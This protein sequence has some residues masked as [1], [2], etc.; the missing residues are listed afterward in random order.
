MT[1]VALISHRVHRTILS[2]WAVYAMS[3]F[4]LIGVYSL[5][6]VHLDPIS[7]ETWGMVLGSLGAYL[8]GAAVVLGVKPG[9][10]ARHP[11][12]SERWFA[13]VR[14][15]RFRVFYALT[16]A[17]GLIGA[18]GYFL[19]IQRL[20]GLQMLLSNPGFIR[21]QQSGSEFMNAFF[22]W[23]FPF[24]MNWLGIGLGFAWILAE[25][26]AAPVW[27]WLAV[28]VQVVVNLA[29]V[30]RSQMLLVGFI[31]LFLVALKR[32]RSGVVSELVALVS[33]VG[34]LALYFTFAGEMLGKTSEHFADL[35][36][37]FRGPEVL[38]PFAGFYIYVAANIP[39]LQAFTVEHARTRTYGLFQ[40]L[41]LA[42]FVQAA[43]VITPELPNEV[44]E[45]VYVPLAF[46]TYTYLNVFF[47]DWGV[48]GIVL[49]PFLFGFL[50]NW[51]FVRTC[52]RGR[53]WHVVGSALIVHASLSSIGTSTLISTPQW[54]M[55]L[56]LALL[57]VLT[58]EREPGPAPVTE[59]KQRGL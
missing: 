50:G 47:L 28:V 52:S 2:P 40:I 30:S 41:P 21:S 42:K 24:Y 15:S 19:V 57:P 27:A 55:A 51:F 38:R 49:G 4:G 11:P 1:V 34:A 31:M 18:A 43:G 54:E 22:W 56:A 59:S 25:K 45:S 26:R 5:E 32:R 20:Y 14:R 12:P 13:G 33:L 17:V 16:V 35:A 29:L 23:K 6:W 48:L 9:S 39:A 36:G 10:V 58:R 7:T 3:W 37:G 46:N 53:V 44:G 8:L